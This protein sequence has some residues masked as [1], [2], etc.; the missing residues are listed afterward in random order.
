MMQ[1]RETLRSGTVLPAVSSSDPDGYQ[2][3][4]E[5][6]G[7]KNDIFGGYSCRALYDGLLF[8]GIPELSVGRCR[9]FSLAFSRG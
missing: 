2:D 7:V 4:I 1:S 3:R 5:N 9:G 8:V 6:D